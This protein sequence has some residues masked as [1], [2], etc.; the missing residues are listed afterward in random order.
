MP[1][2][3]SHT[4]SGKHS[5]REGGKRVERTPHHHHRPCPIRD[6]G[7]RGW[8]EKG[9][10]IGRTGASGGV[11]VTATQQQETGTREKFCLRRT[12]PFLGGVCK[13]SLKLHESKHWMAALGSHTA[14]TPNKAQRRDT[15][16]KLSSSFSVVLFHYHQITSLLFQTLEYKM[17]LT[18]HRPHETNANWSPGVK[19][20]KHAS[21]QKAL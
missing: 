14:D 17:T 13:A 16:G 5:G 7:L 10:L 19:K 9:T 4:V 15:V 11:G 6:T 8:T 1:V 2:Q 3:L 12:L 18:G 20:N 21:S